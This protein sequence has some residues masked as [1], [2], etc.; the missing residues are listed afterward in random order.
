[1]TKLVKYLFYVSLLL[2]LANEVY[3]VVLNV[4]YLLDAY[5]VFETE[6][7]VFSSGPIGGD[8]IYSTISLLLIELVS[9]VVCLLFILKPKKSYFLLFAAVISARFMYVLIG[10]KNRYKFLNTFEWS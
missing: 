7:S 5:N 3:A 10:E 9:S 8:Y 1:M 2:I 4:Q 6:D